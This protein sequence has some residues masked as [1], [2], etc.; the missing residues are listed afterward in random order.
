LGCQW[1]AS[2][3]LE[4]KLCLAKLPGLILPFNFFTD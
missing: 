2:F 1:A 4:R 3:T